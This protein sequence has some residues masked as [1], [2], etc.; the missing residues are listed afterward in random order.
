[1]S[2][3]KELH[4]AVDAAERTDPEIGLPAVG[5]LS[6]WLNEREEDLIVM[7]RSQG[8][9]W[10]QVAEPLGRSRQAMWERYRHIE[11]GAS[12]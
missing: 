3:N 5:A 6:A 2:T 9:T 8:W 10:A 1:V 12:K 4:S 7:A 11:E